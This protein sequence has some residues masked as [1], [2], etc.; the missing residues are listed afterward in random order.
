MKCGGKLGTCKEEAK[1]QMFTKHRG[2]DKWLES[3]KL[4]EEHARSFEGI[5]AGIC[6]VKRKKL[7]QEQGDGR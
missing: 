5:F 2:I 4:C 7:K 6:Q 3:K 1:Y